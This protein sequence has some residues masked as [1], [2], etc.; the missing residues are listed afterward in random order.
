MKYTRKRYVL[1]ALLLGGILQLVGCAKDPDGADSLGTGNDIALYIPAPERVET[2]SGATIDECRIDNAVVLRLNTTTDRIM[3]GEVVDIILGNGTQQPTLRFKTLNPQNGETIVV[4]CNLDPT[5]LA[6]KVAGIV[7]QNLAAAQAQLKPRNV[8]SAA[9]GTAADM[10]A[11]LTMAGEGVW[12]TRVSRSA[13]V[14]MT[15]QCAKISVVLDPSLIQEGG[16][17]AWTTVRSTYLDRMPATTQW[18]TTSSPA[19]QNEQGNLSQSGTPGYDPTADPMSFPALYTYEAVTPANWPANRA[20]SYVLLRVAESEGGSAQYYCLTYDKTEQGNI[21]QHNAFERGKHYVFRVKDIYKRGY[22][23]I[24]EALDNP[25]NAVYEIEVSDDW[26]K[27]YEYNGQYA[28]TSDRDTAYVWTT[29]EAQPLY[30]FSWPQ[31]TDNK[32]APATSTVRLLTAD[33]ASTVSTTLV[34]LLDKNGMAIPNNTFTF[35]GQTS[36]EEGYAIGFITADNVTTPQGMW[37]HVKCGNIEKFVPVGW[38][39]FSAQNI[40]STYAGGAFA[41]AIV[42]RAAMPDG[43][44]KMLEYTAEYVNANDNKINKPDWIHY[45]VGNDSYTI[46]VAP[47]ENSAV[48]RPGSAVSNYDLSTKGGTTQRNTANCYIV[49]AP[50]SYTLPLVYGNAIKKGVTNSA[51]YTS[52]DSGNS[53]LNPFLNHTG[54]GIT[55]PYIKNNNITLAAAKLLWQDVDG[56][57]DESSVMLDGD[58]LAFRVTNSIDYGN[59]VLAV[60]D[61]NGD[62]AWS[63]HIWATDYDPYATDGTKTVQNRISP[64]R[65]FDVMTQNLG[66]CPGA[67]EYKEREVRIT[68]TQSVTGASQTI[69]VK[70]KPYNTQGNN[71]FYQWGRKDPMPGALPGNVNK[72]TYGPNA[73]PST[74]ST[75]G[76]TISTTSIAEYIKNP[77]VFNTNNNM[78]SR[79]SNLWSADN[80][81]YNVNTNPVVKTIYD[82]S[83]VGFVVPPSGAFTGF[84]TTGANASSSAQF[85]T[86]GKFDK[87]WNFFCGLN[88]TGGTIYFPASGHRNYSA[89]AVVYVGSNGLFWSAVPSKSDSNYRGYYLRFTSSNLSLKNGSYRS[90]GF[91]VRPVRE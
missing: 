52:T 8:T 43:T 2:Y 9:G 22:D 46:N 36:P 47:Q 19:S 34:Q 21:T 90:A 48:F 14:R 83:P 10:Q 33:K 42:S 12:D 91:A 4:L 3:G 71:P 78:D 54:A 20:L 68:L 26:S 86:D 29:T 13:Q 87:G 11:P 5:G 23:N 81:T 84:T 7:G 30:R 25:S 82:P 89:G 76:Q 32:G 15:F 6:D 40:E 73:W 70:Q 53:V 66:W 69:T 85:N 57:I 77:F 17:L 60:F 50:G 61:N 41:S 75:P 44:T 27:S 35:N 31:A 38:A 55:D 49:N 58:N 39:T 67:E 45:T 62:I 1:G 56:M 51:S 59:A 74:G 64:N 79:Y 16:A 37:L 80:T 18:T 24:D 88:K 65:E 63:W 72:P 28:V